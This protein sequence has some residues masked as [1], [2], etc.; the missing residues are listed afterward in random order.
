[1]VLCALSRPL[2]ERIE[3]HDRWHEEG[4]FEMLKRVLGAEEMPGRPHFADG[5]HRLLEIIKRGALRIFV[6]ALKL[7]GVSHE[8]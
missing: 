2:L 3:I 5:R 1:M 7:L 6:P 4:I 8:L